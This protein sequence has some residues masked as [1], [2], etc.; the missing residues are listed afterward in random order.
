MILEKIHDSLIF[1]YDP[2]LTLP[3]QEYLLPY[4]TR[5]SNAQAIFHP[6]QREALFISESDDQVDLGL[7]INQHL[8]Q[9]LENQ[10]FSLQHLDAYACAIEG[11]S[12]FLYVVDRGNLGKQCSQ[13]ELELQAEVDKFIL[14]CLF[15]FETWGQVPPKMFRYLFHDFHFSPLLKKEERERYETAHYF[16]RKFCKHL[17]D[18]TIYPFKPSAFLEKTSTFWKL[19]L[20]EK[21]CSLM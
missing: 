15:S 18:E 5:H 4:L 2:S 17:C 21:I 12:H 11:V 10:P 3:L 19:N 8:L 13:L 16:G 14:L 1:L 6:S 20:Q 9:T 7:Y